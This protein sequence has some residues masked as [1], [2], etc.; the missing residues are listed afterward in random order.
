MQGEIA[1]SEY[2]FNLTYTFEK[3]PMRI[4]FARDQWYTTGLKAKA[5]VEK[6]MDANTL[7]DLQELWDVYPEAVIEFTCFDCN[8]GTKPHRNTIIWEVRNY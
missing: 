8:I 2:Y 4:A 1:R 3:A 6:Y 7:N 5:L